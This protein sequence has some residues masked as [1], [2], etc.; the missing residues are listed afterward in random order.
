MV[1]SLGADHVMDYTRENFTQGSKRYDII[2]MDIQMPVMDGYTTCREIRHQLQFKDLP[3]IAMTANVMKSDIEKSRQAGMN[4]HIGKPLHEAEVFAT[5]MKWLQ[6]DTADKQD[7]SLTSDS[8]ERP[9]VLSA[10]QQNG[11]PSCPVHYIP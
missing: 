8:G 1:S 2:L 4:D 9:P 3:V 6:S 11:H 5:L 10:V 7:N